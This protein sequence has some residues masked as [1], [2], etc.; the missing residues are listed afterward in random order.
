MR[1]VTQRVIELGDR[2][3]MVSLEELPYI[4]SDVLNNDQEEQAIQ[5]LNYSLFITYGLRPVASVKMQINGEV[6]EQ[7]ASGDGQYNAISKAM[8]KIYKSLDKATPEL[9]DYVVVI[10]PGGQTDAIVQTIITWKFEDKTFKT[11]GL[12]GDQTVAAIK[13][14]MKMLNILESGNIPVINYN[15]LP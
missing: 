2:K 4:V 13:A 12:D 3:E 8:W 11:R 9:I 14:T 1:K 15:Q 5:I 7:S 10:P 6:Y